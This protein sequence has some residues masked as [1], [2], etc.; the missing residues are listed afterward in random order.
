MANIIDNDNYIDPSNTIDILN[1]LRDLPTLGD[2]KKLVDETFPKWI[3]TTM[4]S[5]CSDYPHLTENWNNLCDISGAVPSQVLIVDNIVF[6]DSHK[7]TK[8][9]CECFTRSGF[10]VRRKIEFFPCEK[11]N[12]AIPSRNMWSEF[13]KK[14]HKI[15]EKWRN[16]CVGC[17]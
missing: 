12:C 10:S 2:V 5:Y 17:M 16:I 4:N 13:K 6:D 9:F 8:T 11:C 15:P 1:K 14:N 7:L 3:I